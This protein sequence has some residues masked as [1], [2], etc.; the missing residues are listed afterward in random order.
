MLSCGS[1]CF[2]SQ[3]LVKFFSEKGDRQI[4]NSASPE[5]P[6]L[7]VEN[8]RDCRILRDHFQTGLGIAHNAKS[9]LRPSENLT[10]FSLACPQE[11]IDLFSSVKRRNL[12]HVRMKMSHMSS[13][14]A[15]RDD[16]RKSAFFPLKDFKSGL[17]PNLSLLPLARCTK[18][19][20]PRNGS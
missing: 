15:H 7:R 4:A 19:T 18:A 5:S 11:E 8:R 12:V 3:R 14:E 1:L 13:H 16:S 9:S 17:R 20:Q 6:G 2:L 10:R